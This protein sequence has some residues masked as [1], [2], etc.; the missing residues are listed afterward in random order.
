MTPC[1]QVLTLLE[2]YADGELEPDRVLEIEAHL[3]DCANC[4]TTLSLHHAVR[5]SLRRAV[6]AAAVP[7]DAFRERLVAQLR[8]ETGRDEALPHLQTDR[9]GGMLSWN[10]ILPLAAA[11]AI[12]LFWSA[13]INDGHVAKAPS[14]HAATA[15]AV[16]V[17]QILEELVN[18]HIDREAPAVTEPELVGEL[19]PEVGV[20]VR[21]PSLAQYGARWV[22]GS[23]VPVRNQRAASLRYQV[24]GHRMT[25][26]VYNSERFPLNTRLTRR[27][28]RDEPV[29][30]GWKRGY[31]I[32]A[33][34]RRGVGY[35]VATDLGEDEGAEIVASLH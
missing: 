23:V 12:A 29:Y 4:G 34:E 24:S 9:H 16:N 1:R 19:E 6:H 5:K 25:L 7:S 15:D 17:D 31:S 32:A 22:G 8:A 3:E 14:T 20:P 26:Y 35:A 28:V 30:T 2:A 18:R 13:R 10:S 33:T 27:V 21:A 11:A